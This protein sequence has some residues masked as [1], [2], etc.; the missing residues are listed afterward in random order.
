MGDKNKQNL[1]IFITSFDGYSDL[2]EPFFTIF[3]Y[4]WKDC[5]YKKYLTSNFKK[6][7]AKDVNML[8]VGQEVNWK[9]RMIDSL[10]MIEEEYVFIFLEDYFL[11]KSVNTR[12]IQEILNCMKK[13]GILMY[14]LAHHPKPRKISRMA[15]NKTPIYKDQRYGVNFQCAIWNRKHLLEIINNL[16]NSSCWDFEYYFLDIANRSEHIVFPHYYVDNRDLLKIQNGVLKG[17]W[18]P[19]TIRYYKKYNIEIDTQNRRMLSMLEM[20][21]QS[22]YS[23]G[24]SIIPRRYNVLVKSALKKLG[25]KFLSEI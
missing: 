25:F 23:F 1:A 10:N 11:G 24:S 14:R 9:R 4:F 12:D 15:D 6:Y 8:P 17:K 3:N 13:E 20:M 19:K 2:W 21:K 16:E 18:I 5:P 22:L 7:D